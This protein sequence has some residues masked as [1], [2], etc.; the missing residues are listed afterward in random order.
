[1][2][3]MKASPGSARQNI[4]ISLA[5]VAPDV[6][7]RFSGTKFTP[8]PLIFDINSTSSFKR[9]KNYLETHLLSYKLR[10]SADILSNTVERLHFTSQ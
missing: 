9:S 8:F 5:R 1:M 2:G 7:T 6:R 4:I 3:R 10:R